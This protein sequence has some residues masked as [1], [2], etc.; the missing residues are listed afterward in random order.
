MMGLTLLGDGLAHFHTDG[1]RAL[2][3]Q[4]RENLTSGAM[5]R[6][7][8]LW[9][10]NRPILGKAIT[11]W[12]LKDFTTRARSKLMVFVDNLRL[13]TRRWTMQRP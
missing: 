1:F 7:L 11:Q 9:L 5:C 8:L 6:G 12:K 4:H 3:P 10:H 2:A 13:Y